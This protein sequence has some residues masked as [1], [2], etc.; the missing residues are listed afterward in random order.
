METAGMFDPKYL[1]W[2]RGL[3]C[4]MCHPGV[5]LNPWVHWEPGKR[6]DP[7][8]LPT[9]DLKGLG[10]KTPDWF[11]VPLCRPCHD[12]R[13]RNVRARTVRV[14]LSR[15]RPERTM[16]AREMAAKFQDVNLWTIVARL[17]WAY[18]HPPEGMET[19]AI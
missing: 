9:P 15:D 7:D 8:H 17:L 12:W 1:R 6:S 13:G 3:P 10:S 16:L 19:W 11:T 18:H 2:I 14:R 5:A 4:V